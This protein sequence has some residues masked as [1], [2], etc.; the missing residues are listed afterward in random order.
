MKMTQK[1]FLHQEWIHPEALE[2]IRILQN[3]GFTTYLVGGCVRDLLL[4]HHPKDFDIA[5][6]ARP[7]E[8]KLHIP[9]SYIIG[10]RFRLVLV[11]REP[12]QFEVATFRRDLKPEEVSHEAIPFG[13]NHFGTPEEDAN[14]RDFTI[15]GLMFDPIQNCL[16]DFCGG[17][18][19]LESRT[20]R[21]IGNPQQRL[22]EDPIRILRGI[23]LAYLVQF[24]IDPE[25]RKSMAENA[26][27]LIDTALPRRREEILKYLRISNPAL[28][29]LES[30]DLGILRYVSPHL[31]AL[32]SQSDQ[33]ELFCYYLNHFH[34]HLI[35]DTDP[36]QLFGALV[37]AYYR[38][39]INSDPYRI[40]S[41]N[42][43]IEDPQMIQFMRNEMGIFKT[44]Q[45]LIARALHMQSTLRKR[46]N[47]ELR[48]ERRQLAVLQAEAFPLALQMALR[49]YCLSPSHLLYWIHQYETHREKISSSLSIKRRK[50]TK[51]RLQRKKKS[52]NQNNLLQPNS[53]QK[54]EKESKG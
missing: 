26:S 52:L 13:D 8:V 9:H 23:R 14:R 17:L 46:E 39:K 51:R 41:T 2:I 24:R 47:F 43:I 36:I 3:R 48:G 18:K 19:D 20:I 40:I 6:L 4:N 44:E 25:L 11:K 49:D 54:M 7:G 42:Q 32:L 37:Q 5:T 30:Y 16:L 28:P 45:A 33:R 10:K 29:F 21:M 53:T 38:A 35:D 50:K 34:D 12:Q 31:N 22:K 15:N 27:A 1:P